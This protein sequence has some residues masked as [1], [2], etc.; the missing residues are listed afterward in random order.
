MTTATPTMYRHSAV[1]RARPV[2]GIER[3]WDATALIL[4]MAGVSLFAM[5]RNALTSIAN[6]SYALPEGSSWVAQTDFH[7]VQS[8]AGLALAAAGMAIGLVAGL[9][10]WR[11]GRAAR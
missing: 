10:H 6:G 11:S 2:R 9:M 7:V 1:L 8:R 5:A 4:V 3:L